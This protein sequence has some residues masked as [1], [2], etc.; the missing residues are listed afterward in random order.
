MKKVLLGTICAIALAGDWIILTSPAFAWEKPPTQGVFHVHNKTAINLAYPVLTI[1]G[2][3]LNSTPVYPLPDVAAGQSASF[4]S[5]RHDP[6]LV[7]V[8]IYPKYFLIPPLTAPNKF[9]RCEYSNI[10]I[11]DV[12]PPSVHPTVSNYK[13]TYAP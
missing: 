7:W 13:F 8:T 6:C 11:S 1:T 5:L 2:I 3:T 10:T 9:D 12:G 4:A